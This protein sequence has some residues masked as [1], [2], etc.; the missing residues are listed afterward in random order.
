MKNRIGLLIDEK[1]DDAVL[2]FVSKIHRVKLPK[3]FS[4]QK[5]EQQVP[6]YCHSVITIMAVRKH[7]LVC[8]MIRK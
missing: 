7:L 6:S 4:Q 3:L 8:C 5:I 2:F 1:M